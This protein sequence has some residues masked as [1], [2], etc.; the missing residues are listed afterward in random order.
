MP[1]AS[2]F[3]N[4]F[5]NGIVIRG[6]PVLQTNPGKV[7]WVSNV[8]TGLLA[9][10]RGGSDGNRGTFDAP[11]ATINY[12]VTQCT[13]GRG[14]IIFVKPGHA[15]TVSTAAAIALNV[16]GV[17]LIGLGRGSARP[18]LTWSTAA[19][20]ITV[21]ASNVT[22]HNFLFV[23]SAAST[24]TVTAF[25]N[26]NAVVANDFTIDSC[27]FRD[28]DA[29]HGF[30]ACVTSGTT[31]NQ[32][33]GLTFTNNKIRRNLTAPPAANTAVV[34]GA[35]IDRLTFSD[36]FISNKAANNNVALGFAL[37]ANAVQNLECA[38][39]RTYSLNTGTTAG[40]LF[41]GGSTTSSGLVYGNYSWHLASSGLLAPV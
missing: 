16:A 33:D 24:F 14:D 39:N 32:G 19:S 2:N 31:A 10:Q 38:N 22:V 6:V 3:P 12:A 7:F 29:T 37:G 15:E 23:G 40:E 1:A 9:G 41:S 25:S 11:F 26:A 20:T 13:A 17:A 27:E 8:T 30:I 36:N 34:I 18:T 28:L 35:A 4:G 5:A 21:A